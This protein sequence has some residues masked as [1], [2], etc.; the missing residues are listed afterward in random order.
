MLL[1]REQMSLRHCVTASLL[2]KG[3]K[4]VPLDLWS[5]ATNGTQEWSMG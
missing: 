1:R 2:P 4:N 5:L 3:R